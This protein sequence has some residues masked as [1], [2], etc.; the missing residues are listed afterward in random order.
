MDHCLQQLCS[1]HDA[2]EWQ[3]LSQVSQDLLEAK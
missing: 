3:G 1:L 2:A